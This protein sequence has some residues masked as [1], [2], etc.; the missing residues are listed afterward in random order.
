MSIGMNIKAQREKLNLSQQ[1]LAEMLGCSR[2]L[3]ARYENG[4]RVPPL[5]MAKA[6][7]DT[8][9]CSIDDLITG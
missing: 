9:G 7:A 2:A 8:F 3:I 4:T 6:I 5:T 1:N